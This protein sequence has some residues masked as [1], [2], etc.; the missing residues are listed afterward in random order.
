MDYLVERR[1][2]LTLLEILGLSGDS[3]LVDIVLPPS[4][5]PERHE[6][7]PTSESAQ[8]DLSSGMY[9]CT[10]MVACEILLVV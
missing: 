4:S 2:G 1:D 3:K 8:N 10:F 9:I 7:T 5:I 6:P